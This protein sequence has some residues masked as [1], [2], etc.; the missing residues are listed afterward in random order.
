MKKIIDYK[1]LDSQASRRL[2]QM[3]NESIEQGWQ[4]YGQMFIAA[5]IFTQPMVKY[6][7]KM[8]T[9]YWS[10]NKPEEMHYSTHSDWYA[11]LLTKLNIGVNVFID[12]NKTNVETDMMVLKV[13]VQ[14]KSIIE[15][16]VGYDEKE[17]QLYR[18][19]I[20]FVDDD[21]NYILAEKLDFF[22]IIEGI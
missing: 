16:V 2:A 10:M 4:P 11:T 14:C 1:V 20:E 15:N 8:R 9:Y 13:P 17:E 21:W 22:I 18:W 5:S 6:A 7:K 3:V 19:K 12:E